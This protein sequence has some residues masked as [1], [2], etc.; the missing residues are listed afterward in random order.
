MECAHSVHH[1]YNL[2]WY[3]SVHCNLLALVE[4]SAA[5][6]NIV[7]FDLIYLNQLIH[8]VLS[9][10]S[11]LDRRYT[12]SF[13]PSSLMYSL[14]RV[15]FKLTLLQLTW[16]Y[17]FCLCVSVV[18]SFTSSRIIHAIHPTLHKSRA[19]ACTQFNLNLQVF[20]YIHRYECIQ[21]KRLNVKWQSHRKQGRRIDRHL[22][23]QVQA[24][25]RQHL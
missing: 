17:L 5:K 25:I 15:L 6:I 13:S 19:Y 14:T 11:L 7:L 4:Q 16:N 24:T 10:I 9:E 20:I 3:E 1:L 18:L 21:W 12:W 22:V 2:L 23:I 8:R